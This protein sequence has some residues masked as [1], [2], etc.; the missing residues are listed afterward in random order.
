LPDPGKGVSYLDDATY[1]EMKYNH[2]T[3]DPYPE[4]T[5]AKRRLLEK[6]DIRPAVT[7]YRETDPDSEI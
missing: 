6:L 5:L 7:V 1:H 3:P 2:T 4:A